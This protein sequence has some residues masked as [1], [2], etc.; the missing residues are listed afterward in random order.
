LALGN[1]IALSYGGGHKVVTYVGWYLLA[2]L[3]LA[4]G[5]VFWV[6][7]HR[8][9]EVADESSGADSAETRPLT[10][11]DLAAIRVPVGH[12]QTALPSQIDDLIREGIDLVEE[13]S[14]PV[15]P[16]PTEGGGVEVSGGNAPREWQEKT[17]AYRQKARNLLAERHPALLKVYEDACNA[18]IQKAREAEEGSA[19]RTE[20]P[21][22]RS[23]LEKALALANWQRGGPKW[24]VEITLDGLAA[25]RLKLEDLSS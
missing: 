18:E 3:L 22:R 20:A 17:D 12:D 1:G 10:Y 2:G 4:A 14:A 11:A 24:E 6:E 15:E 5:V 9:K 23:G 19:D 21:D 7:I 25:A 16:E 8:R 13:F